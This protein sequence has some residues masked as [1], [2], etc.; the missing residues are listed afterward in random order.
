MA[1]TLPSFPAYRPT[2]PPGVPSPAKPI[3][4][5]SCSLSPPAERRGQSSKMT[6]LCASFLPN[7]NSF[8]IFQI[9]KMGRCQNDQEWCPNLSYVPESTQT[10]AW[11]QIL[12]H[13]RWETAPLLAAFKP[14]LRNHVPICLLN[15]LDMTGQNPAHFPFFYLRVKGGEAMKQPLCP[16]LLWLIQ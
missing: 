4:L 8:F 2:P 14:T 7:D 5:Y 6:I 1:Y 12:G 9:Q 11:C 3:Y 10:Q 16:T 13:S 15:Y